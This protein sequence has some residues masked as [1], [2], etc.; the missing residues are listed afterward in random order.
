VEVPA[1]GAE[2]VGVGA[3]EVV[4]AAMGGEGVPPTALPLGLGAAV[5]T[6]RYSTNS[7]RVTVGT[8]TL[9]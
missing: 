6:S 3:E 1:P 2:K 9:V 7:T 8:D 4:A 5:V